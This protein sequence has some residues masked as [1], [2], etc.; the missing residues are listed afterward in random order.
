MTFII[1]IAALSA[2]VFVHELG[3][4]IAA[5]LVGIRI[6]EFAIGF[7]PRIAMRKRGET[8]YAIRSLPLGGFVRLT[9]MNYE[10]S[11][12]DED[13]PRSYAAKSAP[14]KILTLV[15]GPFMNIAFAVFVFWVAFLI[16]GVPEHLNNISQLDK[17][18][19][20]ISSG[21]KVGDI[22]VEVDGRQIRKPE[23]AVELIRARAGQQVRIVV[24]R[25]KQQIVLNPTLSKKDGHGYLGVVFSPEFIKGRPIVAAGYSL[26][27][28]GNVIKEIL[29]SLRDFPELAMQLSKGKQTG[30]SGPVGIYKVTKKVAYQGLVSLLGLVAVLSVSLGVFNV[31]PMPPLDGGHIVFAAIEGITG[32]KI[33]TRIIAV[34]QLIG[35]TLLATL[36]IL[37]TYS[38]IVHPIPGL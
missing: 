31:L 5:R 18:G 24:E 23:T 17:T 12:P 6:E 35:F 9:G 8:I 2:L 7:G 4:Y 38:D 20:A 34:L 19:P 30:L 3:H 29:K 27:T 36:L 22:V 32:R 26:Q 25:D 11:I 28:T 33:D 10:E 14:A 16:I 13:W 37:V 21:F 1:V 15:S